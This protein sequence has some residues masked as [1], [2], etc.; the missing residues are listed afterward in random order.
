MYFKKLIKLPLLTEK[1]VI[2]TL[3]SNRDRSA[4]TERG[5]AREGPE[6][7]RRGV[8]VAKQA[9]DQEEGM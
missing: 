1:R 3:N 4:F 7:R 6:G 2:S 5:G 8:L 9:S